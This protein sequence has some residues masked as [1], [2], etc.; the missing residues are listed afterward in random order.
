MLTL[1]TVVAC[2]GTTID[3]QNT[4]IHALVTGRHLDFH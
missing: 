2:A 4:E 3:D 1:D